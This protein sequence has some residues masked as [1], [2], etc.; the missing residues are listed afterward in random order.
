MGL[1]SFAGQRPRKSDVTI[2]KNYLDEGELRRLN[3]L[4]SAYFDAAEFRAQR[5]EPTYM[6]DWI[7]HLDRLLAAMDAPVLNGA[8]SVSSQS[9]RARAEQEYETYRRRRDAEPTDTE[10]AYLQAIKDAQ[11]HIEGNQP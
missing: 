2:A 4:V 6:A 3:T 9:A 10:R 5:H 11:R 7:A 8:G 1:T